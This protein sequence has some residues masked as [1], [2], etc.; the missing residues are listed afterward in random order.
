MD[1]LQVGSDGRRL[2]CRGW[3][4][5]GDKTVSPAVKGLDVLRLPRIVVKSLPELLNAA[6]QCGVAD[7]GAR[8]YRA[9]ELL[10]GDDLSGLRGE[11]PKHT[12]RLGGDADFGVSV[13]QSL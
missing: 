6:G 5:R 13:V 12:Q 3:Q 4:V 7:R 11:F 1:N 9:E 8:P 2:F 10:F